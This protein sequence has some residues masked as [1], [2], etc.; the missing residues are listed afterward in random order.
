MRVSRSTNRLIALV[1]VF[2]A[3]LAGTAHDHGRGSQS[4]AR[5]FIGSEDFGSR[6]TR[7]NPSLTAKSTDF[8]P[9]CHFR[10]EHHATIHAVPSAHATIACAPPTIVS[11][12]VVRI[13]FT[14]HFSRGPPSPQVG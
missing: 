1:Y 12:A 10:A 8:C 5:K 7:A 3:I 4:A 9:S 11:P 6:F 13:A 14:A 2:A